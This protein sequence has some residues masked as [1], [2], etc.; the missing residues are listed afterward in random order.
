M[1]IPEEKEEISLIRLQVPVVEKIVHSM[2]YDLNVTG[3]NSELK[4]V[5]NA[6]HLSGIKA[7][8]LH[9]HEKD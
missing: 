7:S 9:Q 5:R 6:R 8:D 2:E 1:P 3:F 4:I